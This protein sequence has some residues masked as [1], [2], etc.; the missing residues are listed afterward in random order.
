MADVSENVGQREGRSFQEK[1]TLE[2]CKAFGKNNEKVSSAGAYAVTVMGPRNEK[3]CRA[4][5]IQHD[6]RHT[7]TTQLRPKT[8]PTDRTAERTAGKRRHGHNNSLAGERG[9]N[10]GS[11]VRLGKRGHVAFNVQTAF[12]EI[13]QNSGTAT[14]T[15]GPSDED[16][17]SYVLIRSMCWH[18]REE[19][20]TEGCLFSLLALMQISLRAFHSLP[21]IL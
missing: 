14:A 1:T 2:K 16:H 7:S 8:E 3:S 9:Q 19:T 11:L 21:P 20:D 12:Y 5:G 17:A 4:L 13:V 18:L 10:H 6:H 15:G